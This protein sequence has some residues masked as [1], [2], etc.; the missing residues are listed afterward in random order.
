[1]KTVRTS[2]EFRRV[3]SA[4]REGESVIVGSCAACSRNTVRICA[5]GVDIGISNEVN[6]LGGW[7]YMSVYRVYNVC[8]TT[9][10]VSGVRRGGRGIV[11]VG[12][13]RDLSHSATEGALMARNV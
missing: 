10:T 13:F 5:V 2:N 12:G 9:R 7:W 3:M 1:M 8:R 6:I 4:S 11:I